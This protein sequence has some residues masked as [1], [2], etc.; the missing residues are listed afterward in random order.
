MREGSQPTSPSTDKWTKN[1]G[2]HTMQFYRSI[3]KNEIMLFAG[4]WIVVKNT[5][6]NKIN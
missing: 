5:M 6:L 2:K 4:G 1:Y 3:K